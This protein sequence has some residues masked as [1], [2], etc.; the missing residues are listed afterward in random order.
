MFMILIALFKKFLGY[1][2]LQCAI[3]VFP[4][5]TQILKFFLFYFFDIAVSRYRLPMVYY[6]SNAI[7]FV[8]QI[9]H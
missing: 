2:R 1:I 3:L 9:L 5:H 7:Y 8:V 4:C 6:N